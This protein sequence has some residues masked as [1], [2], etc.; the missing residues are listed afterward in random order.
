LQFTCLKRQQHRKSLF[1]IKSESFLCAFLF[2]E[3]EKQTQK[4]AKKFRLG[5]KESKVSVRLQIKSMNNMKV[6]QL[7][8]NEPAKVK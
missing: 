4:T 8:K 2:L 1:A 6:F 5:S 7:H 3:G